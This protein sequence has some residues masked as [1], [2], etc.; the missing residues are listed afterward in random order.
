[1]QTTQARHGS[2]SVQGDLWGARALDSSKFQEPQLRLLYEQAIGHAGI[3]QGC[4]VLDVGCGPGGSCRLAADAGAM[5]V[6]IDA[7]HALV[8]IARERVPGAQFEIGDMQ[9]LPYARRIV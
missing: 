8:D 9:L 6:G 4:A 3:G 7:S 2:A 1:M 5:V